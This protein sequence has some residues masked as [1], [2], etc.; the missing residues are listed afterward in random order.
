MSGH[1]GGSKRTQIKPYHRLSKGE[2]RPEICL[3]LYKGGWV[4][5][6]TDFVVAYKRR[7][8]NWRTQAG[9]RTG[10]PRPASWH[11]C[12]IP[13]PMLRRHAGK[14]PACEGCLGYA[15]RV[16]LCQVKISDRAGALD[17]GCYDQRDG[18][19]GAQPAATIH[20]SAHFPQDAQAFRFEDRCRTLKCS[21]R[22]ERRLTDSLTIDVATICSK[23][24]CLYNPLRAQPQRFYL[25]VMSHICLTS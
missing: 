10:S 13:L 24:L 6:S 3:A 1:D 15:R 18:A 16:W 11:S 19:G 22:C 4:E 7:R 21:W 2:I 14:V 8:I 17:Q 12:S 25:P 5:S 9:G 20:D 23:E